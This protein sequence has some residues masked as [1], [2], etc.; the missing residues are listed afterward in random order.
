M[1]GIAYVP[2]TYIAAR[3]CAKPWF[4]S[5]Y[6][7]SNRLLLPYSAICSMRSRTGISSSNEVSPARRRSYQPATC[8]PRTLPEIDENM[9]AP[10]QLSLNPQ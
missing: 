7:I 10:V 6:P 9:G 1:A 3:P 2:W 8:P 4:P 5:L